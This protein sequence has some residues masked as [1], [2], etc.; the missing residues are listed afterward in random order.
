[1]LTR[2]LVVWFGILLLASVNGAVRDS[3][4]IPSLGE[5][6]G[7]AVSA[8]L[9]SA[10]VLLVTW[11]SIGWIERTYQRHRRDRSPVGFNDACLRVPRRPLPVRP[12][13]GAP[14]GGLQR[15]DWTHMGPGADSHGLCAVPYSCWTRAVARTRVTSSRSRMAKSV[16]HPCSGR[17]CGVSL[18]RPGRVS[19][20]TDASLVS[21]RP[22]CRVNSSGRPCSE[23]FP[24][25]ACAD[26]RHAPLVPRGAAS[27]LRRYT[28]A[29]CAA[30]PKLV[31]AL[32]RHAAVGRRVE[33]AV[34]PA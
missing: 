9:L 28:A 27:S 4:L 32:L 30:R 18:N 16:A 31:L 10:I 21:S 24:V 8:L 22:F 29:S 34:E 33:L 1:M 19:S 2:A 7:Y 15:P 25:E 12:V 5:R 14:A 11:L 13:M 6:G 17:H 26:M 23:L 20:E 3:W